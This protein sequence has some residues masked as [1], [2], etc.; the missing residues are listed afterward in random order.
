MLP[1]CTILNLALVSTALVAAVPLTEAG[2]VQG[3]CLEQYKRIVSF[4]TRLKL[5]P[6]ARQDTFEG[7]LSP[8]FSI[9]ELASLDHQVE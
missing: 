9:E 8:D 4:L 6:L 3:W 5:Y 1:N 2:D 7:I